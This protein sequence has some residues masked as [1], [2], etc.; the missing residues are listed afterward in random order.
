[1]MACGLASRFLGIF[2]AINGILTLGLPGEN[3][4]CHCVQSLSLGSCWRN[5]DILIRDDSH[6]KRWCI[7]GF[8]ARNLTKSMCHWVPSW[9]RLK[10]RILFTFAHRTSFS[11]VYGEDRF[12]FLPLDWAP[13]FPQA[14]LGS[15]MIALKISAALPGFLSVLPRA[16]IQVLVAVQK[17]SFHRFDHDQVISSAVSWFSCEGALGQVPITEFL[18]WMGGL[19]NSGPNTLGVVSLVVFH[20]ELADRQ[21]IE[22]TSASKRR[23]VQLKAVFRQASQQLNLRLGCAV[24]VVLH[25]VSWSEGSDSFSGA[26]QPT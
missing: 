19:P 12:N 9:S 24:S 22:Q 14:F 16:T 3:L 10:L 8:K 20:A 2:L 18:G 17:C 21:D 5:W 7:F 11:G 1:M 26:C 15:R 6:I 4:V 25:E 13:G 23:S